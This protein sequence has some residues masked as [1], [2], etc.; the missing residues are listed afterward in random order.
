M[1]N[2]PNDLKFTRSHE[3]IKADG[4]KYLVGITDFAQHSLGDIV[5]VELPET[6]SEKSA[7]ETLAVIE[8]VKAVSD[9]YSP[10]AGKVADVNCDLENRPEMINES[11][12]ESWIFAL[13]S[14]DTAGFDALMSADEYLA[15]IAEEESK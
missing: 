5:F 1:S 7:G 13:K 3:W 8:S 9:I 11:P 4:N 10:I 15:F 2:A 6:G 12:Y 14:A